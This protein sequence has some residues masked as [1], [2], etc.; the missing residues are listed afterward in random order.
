M[1]SQ[2]ETL[3]IFYNFTLSFARSQSS[4]IATIYSSKHFKIRSIGCRFAFANILTNVP[5]ICLITMWKW[6]WFFFRCKWP[7]IH[8]FLVQQTNKNVCP[9]LPFKREKW[10]FSTDCTWAFESYVHIL[11]DIKWNGL[12][13]IFGWNIL[14]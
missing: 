1:D 12:R 14:K 2:K 13:I 9:F 11:L 5:F 4:Q 6:C 10:V 8:F 7:Q 3:P